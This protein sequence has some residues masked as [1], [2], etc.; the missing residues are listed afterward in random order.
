MRR[1]ATK[2]RVDS[3]IADLAP[4]MFNGALD[5]TR[6][7]GRK[8]KNIYDRSANVRAMCLTLIDRS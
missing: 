3:H 1:D 8:Q 4:T 6:N 5:Y 7:D 2:V